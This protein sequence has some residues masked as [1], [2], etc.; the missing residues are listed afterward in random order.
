M[1]KCF[2]YEHRSVL[3]N[4]AEQFYGSHGAMAMYA[5][6]I[7]SLID[8][9]R[10]AELSARQVW[11]ADD[12]TAAGRLAINTSPVVAACNNGWTRLWVL[13]KCQ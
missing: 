8:K 10:D 13:P 4:L 5:L 3:G 6:A 9:L 12:A 7:R 1:I 2:D 11:F